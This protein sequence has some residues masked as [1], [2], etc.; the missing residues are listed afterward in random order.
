MRG[1]WFRQYYYRWIDKALIR[2]VNLGNRN[3]ME[4]GE[5][6]AMVGKLG[7]N[8][9]AKFLW[10]AGKKVLYRNFTAKG[11]GEVDVV[12]RDDE[13]LVFCEVKAR[14]SEQFGRPSRAVNRAK[15]RLIIRGANAWL[16]ELNLPEIMFRFDVLEVLLLEG[17]PPKIRLIENAFNTP[18]AGLGM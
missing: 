9:A 15:Q 12:F 11:G 2:P 14:T 10:A 6:S 8:L 17:E 13:T 1:I 4:S 3:E 5:W 7:E 16:R 18:Q